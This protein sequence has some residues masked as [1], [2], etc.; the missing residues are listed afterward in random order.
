MTITGNYLSLPYNPAAALKTLLFYNGEKLLLDITERVDFC[1]PDRRVYFNCSRWKGLDIRIVCE[2]GNTVICDDCTALRN[3]AGKPLIGQ[4][5]YVPELPAHYAEN[6]PF[7]HFMRERGWINDP[8]GPVYYKG[9]YHTFFQTNPVSREHRNMH[10]GHAC[11]DDLF[12]W[13]VLPE[14]LRPDENGEIFSGSAVVSGGKLILYYTAAGGITRL[15]QGKKFEIC[16][17]DSKDGQTFTNFKYSIVPTGESRYSRDPKVVWCEEE[18]VFLMLVYRDESNY[19]LYSSENLSSWRFEQ[20]LELPEDSEC[21]DIYRLY[22]D[23][24][25]SRPFWIISG[26]SDRYLIG[27]FERQYGDEGTKNSGAERIVFVPEQRAGRLHYGNASYAGQSFFGTPDGD[28]KRLTW[29]KTSPAHDLSAGQLSI[30]MQMSLVTGEDRMYLCAQPVKE[31]ERLY[32]RQER[33]VNTATGRGAEAETQ[34][35][36]VLPHSALDILISL[37]PAKKGTVSFSLFGCA[38]DIDFYRNTVECCGCTAPLRAGDGNSD[39]RMIVDRLSLELFIDGGKFYMS[40]ET[41]C[42][43]NL[44]RFTVSADRELVL[45]DIII[46]ELIPVAAGSPAEDADRMPDAG[47]PGAAHVALG[48]DIGSTTLSFD[49]V[50]I[51]TGRELESFTVPNDTALEGRSYEKLYDVDRILKKVRTELEL[52]TGGVK[53]PVPECIGI[54]GQMHGIVYVDAG[55]KAISSLYSWM[56]GTGDVPREALGNKSAAQYLG[57]LTG[58][59]V[60]TGMGLATLLSHTVSGEVPEGAAAVCTVADYIAMRLA[61]RTRPYMHSSNAA[62]LGAYDL[63]SGKFMTDALENAGINCAL[64][65]EVTDGYKVIGQ[66]RGIPLAAAIGD[67]QASFFASVKDPDG[68]VLVNIGT[69]SQISFMTSS[70]GSRPGMEVRPLAGGARIMVG[71]SLCGGRSLSMLESF[72]RDTVRLVS[73][74]ECGGAYSS[75]DRY[76]NEQLSCGGEEAFRHSLAVDTSF[77]GTREEPRRTGSVTGIVPENFTPEELIKGFFFGISEELKDLYIAGGGRKPKLLVIAGGAVRKSKYL[78]KV[79]ERL[80]DCRAA[81]PACG[82]AA[83]YGSTVYAQVAAGL[84]PS[85][86]IPQSKIIY[87]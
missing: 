32:R 46:R 12:H 44:D 11:S 79:L 21:P 54:T 83:A 16:S 13:E 27:R 4:S 48:I 36:C 19:L 2:A 18:Q 78:R 45:P 76:L 6:R 37:P 72:F 1:T 31:I 14:A 10:W 47:Q 34:T 7:I 75:I 55:G 70:F 33:F 38:V 51:D 23:G 22:A 52:L 26:A 77:C 30:P 42:D 24:N 15:S 59:Q 73:G 65:P 60:A 64:L 56:D 3:A 66:Y 81:I 39:I 67:N 80:F 25:T 9:R 29:L 68:A 40:A 86:A 17:A 43:Y 71:S 20:L 87:K 57:E 50:D 85:P 69:G 41:V 63:R 58:A 74:T 5:D 62:S 8:N 84:E 61:D 53:Y 82:E 28:V 35:L 49:I